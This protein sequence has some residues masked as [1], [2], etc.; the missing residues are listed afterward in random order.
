VKTELKR[1]SYLQKRN[2]KRKVKVISLAHKALVGSCGNPE[3]EISWS[4]IWALVCFL[5]ED[6]KRKK[7]KK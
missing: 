2:G 6:L 7:E 5:A 3:N 1:N 4:G